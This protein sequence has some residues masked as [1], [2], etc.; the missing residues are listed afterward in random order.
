MTDSFYENLLCVRE[1]FSGEVRK[2]A[3]LILGALEPVRYDQRVYDQLYKSM[4]GD[5]N[6]TVRDT[7]YA[8]LVKLARAKEFRQ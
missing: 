6:A 3:A 4:T 8:A 5:E 2:Q 1:K 7:A